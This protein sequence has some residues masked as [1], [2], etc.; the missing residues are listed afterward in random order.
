MATIQKKKKEKKRQV[1]SSIAATAD[2]QT[3][4]ASV[5]SQLSFVPNVEA[6]RLGSKWKMLFGLL[7]A[8]ACHSLV[9][10]QTSGGLGKLFGSFTIVICLKQNT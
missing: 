5:E 2:Q 7:Q 8:S 9:P 3:S 10:L 1:P 6:D 4:G